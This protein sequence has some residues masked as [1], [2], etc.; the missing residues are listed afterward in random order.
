M[1]GKSAPVQIKEHFGN[2][3]WLLVD[4]HPVTPGL[5]KN[6]CEGIGSPILTHLIMPLITH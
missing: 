3:K 6:A 1:Q 2:V 4:L 5:Q